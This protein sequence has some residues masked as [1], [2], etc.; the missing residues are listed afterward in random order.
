[1]RIE[2]NNYN[3]D[4]LVLK[5]YLRSPVFASKRQKKPR[6]VKVGNDKWIIGIDNPLAEE[7]SVMRGLDIEHALAIM[8]IFAFTNPLEFEREIP[9]SL[10]EFCK[11]LYGCSNAKTYNKAKILLS[12]LKSCWTKIIYPNGDFK[13]FTVLEGITI[14]GKK[15]R[16]RKLNDVPELW[17]DSVSLHP[18]YYKL[19]YNIES[20]LHIKISLVKQL[21]SDLARAIYMYIPSRVSSST[22]DNGDFQITLSKLLEQL[23]HV[24]PK[25]KSERYKTFTQNK[26]SIIFQLNG[27]E[28]LFGNFFYCK[29]EETKDKKDYKLVC[30]VESKLKTSRKPNSSLYRVFEGSGGSL[31]EWKEKLATVNLCEFN[32]YERDALEHFPFWEKSEKFLKM[33]KC[34]LGDYF[35]EYLGVVKN[36]LLEDK[37]IHKSPMHMLNYELIRA[38]KNIRIAGKNKQ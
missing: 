12:E 16:R 29:L 11:L 38:F 18:E 24:V 35:A 31:Q 30:W 19:I 6:E 36:H 14:L 2:E 21:S 37:P 23:G 4:S 8:G 17:L 22:N 32:G 15:N 34:L 10:N 9:F 25:Y 26:N 3:D 33:A 27:T 7:T 20:R 13:I 5:S 28:L 1:M